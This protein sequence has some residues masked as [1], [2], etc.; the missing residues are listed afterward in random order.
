MQKFGQF[1][2]VLNIGKLNI[3]E[4]LKTPMTYKIE[5]E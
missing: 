3:R 2:H 5:G 1:R 4:G